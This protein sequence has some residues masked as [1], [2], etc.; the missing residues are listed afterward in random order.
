MQ[1]TAGGGIRLS[2]C[3][4]GY[5]KSPPLH[6]MTIRGIFTAN[7]EI[8]FCILFLVKVEEEE[9]G[10]HALKIPRFHHAF[11]PFVGCCGSRTTVRTHR[12][13]SPIHRGE[14]APQR[15]RHHHRQHSG[16]FAD[17]LGGRH[18]WAVNVFFAW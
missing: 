15:R 5:D 11:S 12:I 2:T 4:Q 10:D 8:I 3:S 16:D 18:H 7:P 1:Q 6:V 13:A 9:G 17:L 14:S